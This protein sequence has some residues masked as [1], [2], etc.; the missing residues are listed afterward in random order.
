MPT[1]MLGRVSTRKTPP[2]NSGKPFGAERPAASSGVTPL[3]TT[4]GAEKELPPSADFTKE[5]VV[6]LIHAT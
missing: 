5:I 2:G 6:P 1:A 3:A 4:D